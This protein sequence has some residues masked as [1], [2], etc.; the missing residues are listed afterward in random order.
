[1]RNPTTPCWAGAI[2]VASEVR[3]AAVVDGLTVVTGP[4]SIAASSGTWPRCSSSCAQPRP[5]S[6]RRTT[7]VAPLTGSG[8]HD[9]G[10]PVQQRR[11]DLVEGSGAVGSLHRLPPGSIGA[12]RTASPYATMG[13]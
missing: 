7:D 13:G 10:A 2:P 8:I 5:S 1:M 11:D 12:K 3:A 6:T 4:P 9:V